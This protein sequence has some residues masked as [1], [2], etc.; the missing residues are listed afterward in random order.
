MTS[1]FSN[2]EALSG[3]PGSN[4]NEF[5]RISF[6]G[7]ISS[8]TITADPV[9]GSFVLDD[10]TYITTSAAVPEPSSWQLLLL[11]GALL[12]LRH[13]R[14]RPLPIYRNVER[15]MGNFVRILMRSRS[16]PFFLAVAAF[17]TVSSF[18]RNC[19][20]GLPMGVSLL[21]LS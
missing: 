1:L 19:S 4:P 16:T 12:V 3:D 8:V 14:H 2:N 10:A 6:A 15:Y 21:R 20:V 18:T 17:S 11:G 13:L 9:G 7:G 5:L